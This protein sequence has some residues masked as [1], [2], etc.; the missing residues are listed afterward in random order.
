MKTSG[1]N[2]K[3]NQPE[4]LSKREDKKRVN[5]TW[6]NSLFFQIGFIISLLMVFFIMESSIAY[7]PPITAKGDYPLTEE[8]YVMS[9]F[10]I[11]LP[12]IVE[13]P[14]IKII[15][16]IQVN[17]PKPITIVIEVVPN[18]TTNV[19]LPLANTDEPVIPDTPKIEKPGGSIKDELPKSMNSVEFVPVF[20]GCES[21]ESNSE[22]IACMSSK[23]GDFIK[24][25]FRTERFNYL[26]LDDIQKVYV[27]FK[28]DTFGNI[29]NVIARGSNA[30]LEEEGVRVIEKLPKMKP[31][32]QGNINV[33]VMYMVPIIFKVN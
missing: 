19:D 18:S 24:D 13:M 15:R 23:I 2:L 25:K 21:L 3:S 12:K 29:T 17:I 11:D 8:P 30:K 10:I 4:A 32:R 5:I 31:G 28:I 1:N 26:N 16:K 27:Q 7:N 6:N 33:D 20:P 22:K 14:K 9:D